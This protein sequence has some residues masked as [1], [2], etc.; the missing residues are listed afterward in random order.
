MTLNNFNT[1]KIINK[2]NNAMSQE[3]KIKM[4]EIIIDDI[5]KQ[6]RLKMKTTRSG[7][8]IFS[9]QY[10]SILFFWKSIKYYFRDGGCFHT[11]K[12][13]DIDEAKKKMFDHINSDYEDHQNSV[14]KSEFLYN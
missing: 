5:S 11:W 8:Q 14:I 13:H 12:T 9:I 10:R 6:Y 2:N 3:D 4:R 1:N 7:K